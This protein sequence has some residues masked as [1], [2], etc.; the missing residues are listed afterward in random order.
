[1]TDKIISR[2]EAKT[3]GLKRY[4]TGKPC[5]SGH[6]AERLVSSNHCLECKACYE[7]KRYSENPNKMRERKAKEYVEN[8]ERARA[9]EAK[10]YADDPNKMRERARNYRA[11]SK[12]K[13]EALMA[14][15]HAE[16]GD[17]T[18]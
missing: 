4:F 1:M 2:A 6:V 5:R 12:E 13:Y 18:Q 14:E 11:K 7:K 10:R 9:R 16:N 15:L 8:G 17:E 3:L